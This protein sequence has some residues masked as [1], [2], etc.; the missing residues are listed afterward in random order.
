V[1]LDPV[2]HKGTHSVLSLKLVVTKV[3][4]IVVLTIVR[5]SRVDWTFLRTH[6][7]QNYF[8][9]KALVSYLSLFH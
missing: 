1:K 4:I 2:T 6:N 9:K 7:L 8:P 5:K 3:V